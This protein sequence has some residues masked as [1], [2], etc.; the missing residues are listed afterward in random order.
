MVESEYSMAKILKY[1]QS[2]E[3]ARR[4]GMTGC[5]FPSGNPPLYHPKKTTFG[6]NVPKTKSCQIRL[7]RLLIL[8][9][10]A[11]QNYFFFCKIGAHSVFGDIGYSMFDNLKFRNLFENCPFAKFHFSTRYYNCA[12]ETSGQILIG[13]FALR[14]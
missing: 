10:H 5:L 1:Y 13:N 7:L 4:G 11:S 2:Q 12:T 8:I 6:Q 14:Q 3:Q 9:W